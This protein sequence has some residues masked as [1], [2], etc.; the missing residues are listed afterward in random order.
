[1]DDELQQ[2]KDKTDIVTLISGYVHIK[3]SG[4]NYKGL[5]P[6]H[7]EKSPSFMVSPDLQIFKCFGCFPKGSLIKS[8]AGLRPIDELKVGDYVISG[9]GKAR[10]ILHTHVRPYEGNLVSVVNRMLTSPVVL[11]EDHQ[12][13]TLGQGYT[14]KYKYLSKRLK[15]YNRLP[16][17]KKE[18]KV[19]KYFPIKKTSAG[20]LESGDN[21]LYPINK[22]VKD[23]P[24]L[25][26]LPHYNKI[27][28]KHGTKPKKINLVVPVEKDFLELVGWYLA[29]GSTHRAYIRF[30]FGSQETKKAYEVYGICKR[31]FGL[32]ASFHYRTGQHSGLELTVCHSQLANIFGNFCGKGAGNKH[33]PFEFQFLPFHKQQVLLRAYWRGDGSFSGRSSRNK[34]RRYSVTTI[35]RVLA[36][37]VIDVLLRLDY[38]PSLYVLNAHKTTDGVNHRTAYRLFW[39]RSTKSQKYNLTFKDVDGTSYWILPVRSV[40]KTFFRGDVYNLNVEED[41]SYVANTFAVANCGVGGDVFT[42]LMQ[43]EGLEFKEALQELAQKAGVTLK[44]AQ[45]ESPEDKRRERIFSANEAAAQFYHFILTSHPAGKNALVYLKQNRQVED[46]TIKKFRLGYAPNSFGSLNTYLLKKGFSASEILEAGLSARSERNNS[47][48]DRF[49]ARVVFPLFDVRGR[50]AGFTGR[51]IT[52]VPNVPKYLN[53]PE[54]QVFNKSRF[55]FGL[56]FARPAIKKAGRVILVEG[57]V[58]L[59]SNVQAGVE[60]IVATSGTALTAEQVASL[61]KLAHEIIFCFDS[62]LAGQKALERAVELCEE[63][64]LVSL[65]IPIPEGAKDPDDAT[66][67]F[68]QE[69]KAALEKPVSFYDYY[70][71]LHTQGVLKSDALG[72][73]RATERLLPLIAKMSD[74]L[75]K[76]HFIKKLSQSLDLDEHFVQEALSNFKWKGNRASPPSPEQVFSWRHLETLKGVERAEILRKYFLCLTLRFNFDLVKKLLSKVSQKDFAASPLLPIFLVVRQ[77][78]AKHQRAFKIKNVRNGLES[79]AQLVFDELLLFDLGDLEANLDLQTHEMDVVVKELKRETLMAEVSGLLDQIRRAERAGN[80][81]ELRE[82]QEKLNVI[83]TRLKV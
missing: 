19:R 52:D 51:I 48:Y 79:P 36:E 23:L 45:V 58:D 8:A 76:A 74:S 20:D 80:T 3:K 12:V 33:L 38:F 41:N 49:R 82:Y 18:E 16:T 65:V 66:R 24:F 42:F 81:K 25:D 11:T 50:V 14:R 54:T 57:Q 29:E 6:F 9:K 27:L 59:I 31:L 78:F 28:P 2:I 39:P 4:R 30:S 5:C 17:D 77:A 55:L 69:W 26:L 70:F 35:S 21:L 22:E 47:I 62:D 75:Q 37:Q 13:F 32:R 61:G 46:D 72:K 34:F 68:N 71:D 15:G 1:M 56:N 10:K 83:Y 43:K 44:R 53:S 63:Q 60:N 64:G 40:T 67:K 73:R 7:S